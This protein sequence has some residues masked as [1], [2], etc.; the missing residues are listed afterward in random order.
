LGARTFTAVGIFVWLNRA[1]ALRLWRPARWLARCSVAEFR[2]LLTIGFPA[3]LQLLTEVTAFAMASL[4]IGTLGAVPLAAHQVAI[5]CAATAFMVPLG[6]GMA[7]TVRVG[8]VIGARE[9]IVSTVCSSEDGSSP[10]ASCCS[11]WRSSFS[12]APG[13]PRS[14]SL[15]PAW[16]KSPPGS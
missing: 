13:S 14:S 15:M 5:T 2:T 4:F 6:I 11:R 16:W 9:L 3:S 8:E 10:A 7:I 12:T 1:A